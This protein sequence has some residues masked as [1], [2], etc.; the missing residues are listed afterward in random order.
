LD[1][2]RSMNEINWMGP[3]NPLGYGVAS[4]NILGALS[5]KTRLNLFPIGPVQISN[6]K[7][8]DTINKALD[9]SKSAN[10]EAPTVKIWHQHALL[11]RVGN[12]PYYGFPIFELDRF[13]EQELLNLRC[14][15]K[16]LVCS[17]WAKD[18]LE[19]NGFENVSVVP[20]GVDSEIFYPNEKE[21]SD[22]YK[23][24][25][26]GKW[27]LRKGH[28]V[29]IECF[30]KAFEENDNV[31][32]HMATF[33]PFFQGQM[34][35]KAHEWANLA[36]G[37]KLGQKIFLY[38]QFPSH[39]HIADFIRQMDCGLFPSRAEGWNL[40]LLESMACGKPVIATNYSAHT[41]FCTPE[42]SNLIDITVSETANDGV[43]FNGQ[44][45]WAFIGQRQKAQIIDY[46]RYCYKERP[47][48]KA[49]IRT[50]EHFS[51][52][53]SATRLLDA[54]S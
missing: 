34:E 54:I 29:I 11:E 39:N 40:E 10:F 47:E 35:F 46:M 7:L 33:N 3:C 23:F 44:G 15:H 49:G 21:N 52:E 53:N 25:T 18:I 19:D 32:L 1:S 28:D 38:G 16:L 36:K 48:N 31:E 6:P 41:E 2:G 43:W 45:E 20:L 27:E 50:A 24:F 37:S 26:I 42:N 30:N 12:G 5:E 13:T 14:P 51:W 22:T 17:N 8:T 9:N 4:S